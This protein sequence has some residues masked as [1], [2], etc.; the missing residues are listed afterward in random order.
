[1]GGERERDRKR[2]RI[3]EKDRRSKRGREGET[4]R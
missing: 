4:E 2:E 1:M 3:I